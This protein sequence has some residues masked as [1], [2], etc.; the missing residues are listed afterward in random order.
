MIGEIMSNPNE[1]QK[2]CDLI[3]PE[4]LYTIKDLCDERGLEH[5]RESEKLFGVSTYYLTIEA[6]NEFIGILKGAE[7]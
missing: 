4:Q 2:Y 7:L 1:A 5:S 6:A 3:L